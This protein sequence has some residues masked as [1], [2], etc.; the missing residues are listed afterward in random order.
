[1]ADSMQTTNAKGISVYF[2]GFQ[3]QRIIIYPL[4]NADVISIFMGYI[5]VSSRLKDIFK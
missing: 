3:K 5:L 4:Y 2:Y 1:M